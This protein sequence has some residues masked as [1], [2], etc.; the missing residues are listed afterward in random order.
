MSRSRSV[1][2]LTAL[3]ICL[4]SAVAFSQKAIETIEVTAQRETLREAIRS[5]VSQVTRFDGENVAGPVQLGVRTRATY[6]AW[7]SRLTWPAWQPVAD[8]AAAL[9]K[10]T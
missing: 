3:A 10:L 6:V 8:G 2:I 1:A 5:Y 4:D 7:S 9:R